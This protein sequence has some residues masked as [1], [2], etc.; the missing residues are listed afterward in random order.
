M[1]WRTQL[2]CSFRRF[3]RSYQWLTRVTYLR[4]DQV[5][6]PAEMTLPRLKNYRSKTRRIRGEIR[7]PASW[8]IQSPS[9]ATIFGL[10]RN[11]EGGSLGSRVRK[12][13]Q[14]SD[15]RLSDL[16]RLLGDL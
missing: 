15:L 5:L 7:K 4:Q 3:L 16:F 10:P 12:S 8:C 9:N 2:L 14:S 1:P 11:H 6:I 13:Q